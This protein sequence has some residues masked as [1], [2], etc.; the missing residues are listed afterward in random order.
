MLGII[1]KKIG[2]TQVFSEEGS[3]VPVTIVEAGPC[4]VVQKKTPQTDGYT[5]LQLGFGEKKKVNRA[6]AG[7]FKKSQI[8]PLGKLYEFHI[9]EGELD[10]YQVGQEIRVDIFQVGEVLDIVGISKGR[11]F[12][13]VVKRH[14]FKG[15]PGSHGSTFHRAAGSIGASSSPSRVYPGRKM[16]GHFGNSQVTIKNLKLIQVD[17]EKNLLLVKGAIPGATQGTVLVYKK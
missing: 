11:G 17:K 16:P 6:Q 10:H 4:R 13:G 1:G 5:A 3:L 2:M 9:S 14:G 15:G 12:Q 7:H 8:T